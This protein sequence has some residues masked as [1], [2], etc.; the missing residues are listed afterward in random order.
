MIP[1]EPARS[2]YMRDR[3]PQRWIFPIQ[4]QQPHAHARAKIF[5]VNPSES[6][7]ERV[8]PPK[9]RAQQRCGASE[10]LALKMMKGCGNLN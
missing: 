3:W 10:I 6:S 8:K 5:D 1:K 4:R 7:R 9:C 2:S